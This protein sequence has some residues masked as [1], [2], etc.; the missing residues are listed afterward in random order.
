MR[1]PNVKEYTRRVRK[2][3]Q[4]LIFFSTKNIR[5]QIGQ[6]SIFQ[7]ETISE[8]NSKTI[9][10]TLNDYFYL[11]AGFLQT[12][13]KHCNVTP[14]KHLYNIANRIVIPDITQKL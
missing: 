4:N 13:R 6:A 7:R 1:S 8:N 9:S 3:Q 11:L 14:W 12:A 2:L 10:N 5:I